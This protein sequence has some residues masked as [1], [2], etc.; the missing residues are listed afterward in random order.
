MRSWGGSTAAIAGLPGLLGSCCRCASGAASSVNCP[1]AA[2]R[3]APL[4]DEGLLPA[5]QLLGGLRRLGSGM[6]LLCISTLNLFFVALSVLRRTKAAYV[7]AGSVL[8]SAVRQAGD[9]SNKP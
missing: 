3:E 9:G 2:S 5:V 6:P 4:D 8:T 1:L 7:F